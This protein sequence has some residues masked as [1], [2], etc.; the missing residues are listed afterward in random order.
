[1]TSRTG[2]GNF[3]PE[4]PVSIISYPFGLLVVVLDNADRSVCVEAG[5]DGAG[6]VVGAVVAVGPEKVLTLLLQGVDAAAVVQLQEGLG[7]DQ[8]IVLIGN[9]AEDGVARLRA[10]HGDVAR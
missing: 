7:L 10:V 1:M 6:G 5:K 2:F 4:L 8:E 9:V 3:A